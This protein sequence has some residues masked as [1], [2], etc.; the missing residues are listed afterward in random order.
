MNHARESRNP[1]QRSWHQRKESH[2]WRK[3]EN[4]ASFFPGLPGVGQRVRHSGQ[5]GRR[6]GVWNNGDD[7]ERIIPFAHK[8]AR[9]LARCICRPSGRGEGRGSKEDCDLVSGLRSNVEHGNNA[10][11]SAPISFQSR[12]FGEH[13]FLPANEAFEMKNK[14]WIDCRIA[15]FRRD[16]VYFSSCHFRPNPQ[17]PAKLN[18][19]NPQECMRW[20]RT[21]DRCLLEAPGI[22]QTTYL[23]MLCMLNLI[24]NSYRKL[25]ILWSELEA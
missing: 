9:S 8:R 19:E 22:L 12:R 2:Y 24:E 23:F 3:D 1:C 5:G 25:Y 20:S 14:W 16:G 11:L 7:V 18:N 17:N 21:H 13:L 15:S 10:H 6:A 4:V